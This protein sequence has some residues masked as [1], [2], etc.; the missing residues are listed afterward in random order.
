ML[1]YFLSRAVVNRS[2][3]YGGAAMVRSFHGAFLQD[4]GNNGGAI[5]S[6]WQ[7]AFWWQPQENYVSIMVSSWHNTLWENATW[8]IKR[9]FQPS[10]IRRKR[11]IGFLA[12]KRSVGGRKVL[13]RRRH[14]GRARLAG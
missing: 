9:T 6:S 7:N 5:I 3:K 14:K 12:R 11:K 1:S 10:I 4:Q 8:L 13:N 2:P